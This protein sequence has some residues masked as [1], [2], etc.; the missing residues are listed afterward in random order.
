MAFRGLYFSPKSDVAASFRPTVA[1][2]ANWSPD[3]AASQEPAP[4]VQW[5]ANCRRACGGAKPGAC[6]SEDAENCGVP[7]VHFIDKVVGVPM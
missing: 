3:A 1:A 6:D 2:F 7:Q 5:E 4:T